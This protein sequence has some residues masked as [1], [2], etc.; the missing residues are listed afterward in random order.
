MSPDERCDLAAKIIVM[1]SEEKA[2][3]HEV[4]V[5]LGQVLVHF[6]AV[7]APRWTRCSDGVRRHMMI[8]RAKELIHQAT[9]DFQDYLPDC[10]CRFSPARGNNDQG[11]SKLTQS[12]PVPRSDACGSEQSNVPST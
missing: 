5:V 9:Q 4:E 3:L 6:D 12:C 11:D 8:V 2:S 1:L 7:F 10:P